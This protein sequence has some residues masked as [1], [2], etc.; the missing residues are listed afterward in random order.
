[1]KTFNEFLIENFPPF[2]LSDY[3]MQRTD[4]KYVDGDWAVG[5]ED[6]AFEYDTSKDGYKNMKSFENEVKKDRKKR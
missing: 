5:E 1:M 2:A 3:P 4:I 6:K